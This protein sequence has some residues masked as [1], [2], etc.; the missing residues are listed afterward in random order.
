MDKRKLVIRILLMLILMDVVF[1]AMFFI[2]A[3]T[4]DYW[5]AWVYMAL[6]SG[7]MLGITFYFIKRDP[8]LLERRMHYRE[9]NPQQKLVIA[10]SYP[11]FVAVFL[12]PGFDQRFGW[13]NMHPIFSIAAMV[14]AMLAYGFVFMVFRENSYTSRVIE[15]EAGQK[16]ITSGPY[17]LVRHPMYLGMIV[18]YIFTPLAL[19]SWLAVIPALLYI[20]VLIF[21]ILDEEDTLARELDGYKEYMQKTK[22]HMFPKIW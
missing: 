18:M 6:L 10:L 15:V 16:V 17:T 21:R 1:M 8:G 9:R 22:Y 20:P 4:L 7:A 12:L 19:G 3:G 2:P 5:Q 14:I 13:S 11:I